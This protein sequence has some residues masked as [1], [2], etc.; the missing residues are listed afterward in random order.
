MD[1]AYIV[2]RY[3]EDIEWLKPIMDSCVIINKGTKLST[4]DVMR[5]NVGRE[6]ESYL[7]YIIEHYDNLPEVCVFTQGNIAD[8]TKKDPIVYLT[9]LAA[10]AAKNGM[11]S[12]RAHCSNPY[13]KDWGPAWNVRPGGHFLKENYRN[14][15][16]LTFYEWFLLHISPRY[17]RLLRIHMNGI[18]AIRRDLILSRPRQFYAKL[19][20]EVNWH[21]NPIEGHFMERSWVY[22]FYPSTRYAEMPLHL[23]QK[24]LPEGVCPPPP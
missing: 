7:Y 17:P 22:I 21:S 3:T 24:V 5:E 2:S 9:E 12:P 13:D 6:S 11:S 16:L 14:N 23:L 10:Q 1:V 8:H 18:F 20:R 19:I 15:R 4:E